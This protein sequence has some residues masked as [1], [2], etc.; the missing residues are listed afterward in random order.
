MACKNSLPPQSKRCLLM[1]EEMMRIGVH[2]NRN[3]YHIAFS[4]CAM[5]GDHRRTGQVF[6]IMMKD[7]IK[8][9]SGTYDLIMK[10]V[11]K[12][13]KA[14]DSAEIYESLKISGV[15]ERIAYLTALKTSKRYISKLQKET[16]KYYKIDER[17]AKILKDLVEGKR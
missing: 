8:P 15:P 10:T 17:E 11:S 4:A 9:S 6:K 7:N 14:D 5:A 12:Y 1:L 2:G 13:G 3:L 16:T